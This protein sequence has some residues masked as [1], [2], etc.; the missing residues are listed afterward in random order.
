MTDWETRRNETYRGEARRKEKRR[1]KKKSE[2]KRGEKTK[3]N[4]MSG[5][6][7]R[8]GKRHSPVKAPTSASVVN[9]S[10]QSILGVPATTQ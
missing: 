7:R 2:E 10:T 6:F 4:R 3:E 8:L 9:Y 5:V 1:G